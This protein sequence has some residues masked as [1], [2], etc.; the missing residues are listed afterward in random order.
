MQRGGTWNVRLL[1]GLGKAEQL[2]G[3]MERFRRSFLTVTETL[4]PGEGEVMLDE[5]TG[6]C[7]LFSGV[8]DGSS[9]E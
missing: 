8:Q 4:L 7:M 9:R 6:H 5:S 3:E 2:A 1:R